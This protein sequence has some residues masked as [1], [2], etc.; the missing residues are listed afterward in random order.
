[1]ADARNQSAA[2]GELDQRQTS[3][4]LNPADMSPF[5]ATPSVTEN[6]TQTLGARLTKSDSAES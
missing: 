1:M 3:P 6:T 4:A 5:V 2:T